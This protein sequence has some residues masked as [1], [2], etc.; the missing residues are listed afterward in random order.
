[1]KE[2]AGVAEEVHDMVPGASL[3][4][5][6]VKDMTDFENA[7]DYIHANDIHVVNLSLSW[8]GQS[9][10]DDSGPFAELVNNSRDNNGIFW[11]VA[12]GNNA[13]SHWSGSWTDENGDHKL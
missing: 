8:F 12:A 7:V 13:K 9:Y 5:L 6:E 3:F 11:V 1:M 2:G 10:Y 4:L